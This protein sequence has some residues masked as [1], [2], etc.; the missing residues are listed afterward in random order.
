[1]PRLLPTWEAPWYR[2]VLRVGEARAHHVTDEAK[3]GSADFNGVAF[4][5][6][7]GVVIVEG[8]IPVTIEVTVSR[9]RV[10]VEQ[11]REVLGLA[12]YRTAG[13]PRFAAI[14][15]GRVHPV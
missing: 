10:S 7:R 13:D 8:N 12:R 2:W 4:D 1:M 5:P 14:Y 15:D 3:I 11:T 6:G 9:V